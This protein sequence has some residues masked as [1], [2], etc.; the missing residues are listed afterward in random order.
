[1]KGNMKSL[2]A[3]FVLV[4]A[5]LLTTLTPAH[6][7]AGGFEYWGGFHVTIEGQSIR[8]PAGQLYHYISG[9]GLR[10]SWDG[11]NYGSIAPLCDTSVRFTYGY[12]AYVLRGNVHWGCSMGNQWKYTLHGWR[13]P[14]GAACAELWAQDWRVR[15]ARQCHYITG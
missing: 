13:A 12:G 2:A 7:S 10:V 6:A 9:S 14:R 15:V 4:G 1:M 5:F 11:A 3:A 8:I